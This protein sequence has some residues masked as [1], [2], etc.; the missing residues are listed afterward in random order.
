MYNAGHRWRYD[1]K[2]LKAVSHDTNHCGNGIARKKGVAVIK[3]GNSACYANFR[4]M[5][6]YFSDF[7][8]ESRLLPEYIIVKLNMNYRNKGINGGTLSKRK[9]LKKKEVRKWV[10]LCQENSMIPSEVNIDVMLARKTYGEATYRMDKYTASKN[11]MY[12]TALRYIDENPGIIRITLAYIDRGV[13]FFIALTCAHA[14]ASRYNAGHALMRQSDLTYYDPNGYN[15]IKN[16][17]DLYT[18]INRA[19]GLKAYAQKELL[20][21][22]AGSK[23]T[24]IG[25]RGARNF[26]YYTC[27]DGYIYV[28]KEKRKLKTFTDLKT[29]KL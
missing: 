6:E 4:Y 23:H 26:T 2:S 14:F 24:P 5:I 19:R 16:E 21:S 3:N 27:V 18:L 8:G 22:S 11:Y 12:L 29:L 1:W 10:S 9:T 20:T 28:T 15:H 25:K 7:E 17:F 13:D